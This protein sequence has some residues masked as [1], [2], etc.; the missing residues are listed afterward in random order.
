MRTVVLGAGYAGLTA[1]RELAWRLGPRHPH[2]I[3][4]VDRWPYHQLIIRLHEVAAASIP[5][6][7]AVVPIAHALRDRRVGFQ[8]AVVTGLDADARRVRTDAGDI[9][10]DLL[11]VA[12]GSE[13]RD[14]GIPGIRE[15]SLPLKSLP[16]AMRIRR[17]LEA[18]VVRA[19]HERDS[20][21]RRARLTF[22]VGGGGFTGA[23]LAG[24]VLDRV[25][26]LVALHGLDES[27]RVVVLEATE[28]LL[29]GLPADLAARAAATL[30]ARGA[31]VRTRA[32]VARAGPGGLVLASGEVI[33][34]ETLLWTGG[35]RGA[36]AIA[37]SG[38]P[39][40]AG[41][42]ARVDAFL[43]WHG[44][45]GIFAIG[46]AS[47]VC[48]PRSGEP[49]APSAQLALQEGVHAGANLHRLLSG[50]PMAPF[51]PAAVAEVV[52]LGR[53]EAIALIGRVVIQGSEARVLKRLGYARY[54]RSVG[55]W[56]PPRVDPG[57][58]SRGF[59]VP[60]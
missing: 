53:R 47:V 14:F 49:A 51:T 28:R 34:A 15:H 40:G 60:A 32:P 57:E 3:L 11:V 25:R 43:Q 48:D 16:D 36:P 58:L 46:D 27:P 21:R 12:L 18:Q 39:L 6:E 22:V 42:R 52:S 24:E 31:E 33:A 17:H 59:G 7:D 4:L 35:V 1:A 5:P 10:F 38:L 23:E 41:R 2:E 13:T 56:P 26:D 30:A 54:L 45:A 29:P 55:A 37:A 19:R 8:R 50:R 9:P 20:D 44:T